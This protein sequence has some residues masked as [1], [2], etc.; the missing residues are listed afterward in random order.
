MTTTKDADG[1]LPTSL[2]DGVLRVRIPLSDDGLISLADCDRITNLLNSPP[3]SAHV[4]VLEAGDGPFCLG[5]E[6]TA[7][8]VHELPGE[9]ERLV[10]LNAALRTTPLVSVAKVS[11]DAAGYGVGLAALA[12]VAIASGAAEFRFPEVEIGL[13]PS[14]V[15]AWLREAVGRRTA[16][17]LTA[18]GARISAARAV[19]LGIISEAVAPDDLESRVAEVVAALR[20]HDPRIHREIREFLRATDQATE[21]HATEMAKACLVVG[22]LR[23]QGAGQAT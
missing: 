14:L 15:L 1:G 12:D 2:A 6:R 7:A 21:E 16:F 3:P 10:A 19:E 22:S 20:R 8:T 5:R 18:T 9:V 23:R 13:A 17:W 4:V 11:G